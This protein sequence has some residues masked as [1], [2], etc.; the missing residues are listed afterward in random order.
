M[1]QPR[2]KT[3]HIPLTQNGGLKKCRSAN[4]ENSNLEVSAIGKALL[5]VALPALSVPLG[6]PAHAQVEKGPGTATE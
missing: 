1:V 4:L 5:L 6:R 2:K 3:T